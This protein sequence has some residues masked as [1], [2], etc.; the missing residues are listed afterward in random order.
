MTF[1]PCS[2][3]KRLSKWSTGALPYA[4][5][6]NSLMTVLFFLFVLLGMI[7]LGGPLEPLLS[8]HPKNQAQ[9]VLERDSP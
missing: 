4:P 1:F 8:D 7:I 3:T 9:M 2:A 5:A 6:V